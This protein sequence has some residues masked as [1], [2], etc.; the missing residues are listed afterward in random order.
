MIGR[1]APSPPRVAAALVRLLPASGNGAFLAADM[2]QE[3]EDLAA[4]E[5]VGAARRWY[6]KQA[7]LSAPPLIRQSISTVLTSAA[8]GRRRGSTRMLQ[9]LVNDLKYG[10]RMGRRSPVVTVSVTIAIALGIAATTAIFSV[11]EGVFLRPLPFPAPDRLVRFSTTIESFGTAPEVN[12][13]DAQDY[14]ASSTRVEAIGIYDVGA[15]TL[16]LADG[17][18]PF[19]A[20]VMEASA[21]LMTVLG[22]RPE[23]GRALAPEEYTYGGPSSVMLGHRFWRSHF[24]GDPAVVGRA[25]QLGT[26]RRTIVGVL[27]P[28]AD[29]FPAGGADVWAP[30]TF[31]PTSFLNQRGSIALSAIG[32]LRADTTVAAAQDEISTIGARLAT[33]Y[34][35]TNRVRK[36]V[37]D[38]LQDAMVGP[39]KPM[40][41]LLA[42]SIAMLLAVA[43][44]NIANLLLAQAH[45]RGLELGI[46]AAVGASPGRLAR[47]LWTESLA[48]FGIAGL[49]GVALARPLALALIA[50]LSG[51]AAAGRGRADR[52]ESPRDRRRLHARRGAAGG[53]SPHAPAARRAR[54]RRPARRWTERPDP[55]P[56][57]HDGGLRGR[58]GRRFD[59]PPRRRRP[60]LAD[61]HEP[62]VHGPGIRSRRR[63]HDP[64][65]D[66]GGGAT[67]TPPAPSPSRICCATRP[68]RCPASPARRTP[69]SSRSRRETW[70]DGYRRVGMKDEPAPR[71]PMAHFFMV[72]P[73]YLQVMGM[74]VLRGR[75][76]AATDGVNSG[77][78]LVVSETFAKRAFPGQDAVGRRID[79]NDDTWEIAGIT[80]D[81]RHAALGD[82]LDADVYVPRTQVV[83]GNTWLLIKTA[84]PP[85]VILAELQE[86]M[87]AIDPNVA[88]T[89]AQTDAAAPGGEHRARTLPRDRHRHAGRVDAAARDRRPARRRLLRGGAAHAGNRRPSRARTAPGRGRAPGRRR[90]AAHDRRGRRARP[91]RVVLRRPL[92]VV[93]GGGEREPAGRTRR[94][95][96]DLRRGGARRRRRSRVAG[97]PGRS[98]RGAE[99][100]I[101]EAGSRKPGAGIWELAAVSFQPQAGRRSAAAWRRCPG[102][103]SGRTRVWPTMVMKLVSPFQR[104]TM[105]RWT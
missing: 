55:G 42:G 77:R 49:L 12:F 93:G 94:G 59:G 104:G 97:E 53:T 43:C 64:R 73:E 5:G 79:W 90:H 65:L 33:A 8:R 76:I 63:R 11:M 22:L 35:D 80:V 51:N 6:W 78:V 68:G 48:L 99:N 69:C 20:T 46:R 52:R 30:L 75:G 58:P 74:P 47:Q 102:S 40:M 28:E 105:C 89:D 96:G 24:G 3:F 7:C 100:G 45:A 21:G 92:A 25:L 84:R 17:G 81:V 14:R 95:A 19:S 61:V 38:G 91:G 44:A 26:E 10:W 2:A 60:A 4:A 71:G 36:V 54:R 87:K 34:P 37:L 32:R 98:D 16:R 103:S 57:P 50:V 1:R 70:G 82:A 39:V 9:T 67:R 29:R 72:S 85:G 13:L 56:S 18:A 88:L 27:P 86:R 31:P 101:S 15:G 23:L 62:R 41:L 66:P 83:R